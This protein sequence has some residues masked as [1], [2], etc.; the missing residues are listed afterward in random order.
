MS[1]LSQ[2]WWVAAGYTVAYGAL[3][4]YLVALARRAARARRRQKGLR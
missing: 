1:E 4:T 2:W 3:G